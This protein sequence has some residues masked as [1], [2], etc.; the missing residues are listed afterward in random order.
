MSNA[1]HPYD[2]PASEANDFQRKG[3]PGRFNTA[4][5]CPNGSTTN[6]TGSNFGVGAI[7]VPTSAD[8]TAY[9]SNGGQI[10]LSSIAGTGIQ[11]LSVE[12]ITVSSGT[13]YALKRNQLVR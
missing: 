1:T 13:I 5:T 2:Y 10:P 3:H 9:L 8:G 4:I 12:K 6:F 7:I 11:E